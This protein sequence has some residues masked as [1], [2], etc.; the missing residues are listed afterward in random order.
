MLEFFG[1]MMGSFASTLLE[2]LPSSPFRE[3]IEAFSELPY[4]GYLNWFIPV[5]HCVAV[6]ASWLAAIVLFYVY[7]IIMR[8]LK[9]IGD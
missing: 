8:W 3:Y 1:E 5:G 7:S 9:M 2:V 4:L 6:G